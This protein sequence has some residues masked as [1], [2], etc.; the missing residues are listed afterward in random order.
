MVVSAPIPCL[1]RCLPFLPPTHGFCGV[2]QDES[3]IVLSPWP[4]P[5]PEDDE[6][7][8]RKVPKVTGE[9]GGA[10]EAGEGR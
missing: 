2:P 6:D 9:E 7:D 5:S 3:V 1:P 10:D 8:S 4:R